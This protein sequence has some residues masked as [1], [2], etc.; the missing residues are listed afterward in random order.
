[1]KRLFIHPRRA[2]ALQPG[3]RFDIDS[4]LGGSFTVRFDK[5]TRTTAEF[6]IVSSSPPPEGWKGEKRIFWR[7]ELTDKLFLLVPQSPYMDDGKKEFIALRHL[8]YAED[9]SEILALK[10][11]FQPVRPCNHQPKA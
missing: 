2:E 8:G 5:G 6:T 4:G 9:S 11:R 10:R 7:H 3:D 1:M